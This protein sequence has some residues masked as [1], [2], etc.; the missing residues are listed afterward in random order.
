MAA[1][2]P[3]SVK[4]EIKDGD[5]YYQNLRFSKISTLKSDTWPTSG[6]ATQPDLKVIEKE[7]VTQVLFLGA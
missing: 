3:C 2:R 4:L 5:S 1:C 7:K 6:H